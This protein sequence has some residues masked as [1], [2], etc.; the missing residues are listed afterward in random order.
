L[1]LLLLLLLFND[2]LG[3]QRPGG[4]NIVCLKRWARASFKAQPW[5]Q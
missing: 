3:L 5:Q 4:M 2:A 1:L